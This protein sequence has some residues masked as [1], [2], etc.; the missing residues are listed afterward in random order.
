MLLQAEIPPEIVLTILSHLPLQSLHALR[1]LSHEWLSWFD[2]NRSYIY[3]RAALKHNFIPST[4]IALP[5]A[6]LASKHLLPDFPVGD[7]GTFCKPWDLP[8]T[9]KW[10][11]CLT[12][13]LVRSTPIH[14]RSQVGRNWSAGMGSTIRGSRRCSPYQGRR[15]RWHCDHNAQRWRNQCPRLVH[16]RSSLGPSTGLYCCPICEPLLT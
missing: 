8:W 1:R 12:R 9:W 16:R 11:I 3:Q 14:S 6:V 2:A 5:N 4:N 13:V 7:W 15:R 10:D